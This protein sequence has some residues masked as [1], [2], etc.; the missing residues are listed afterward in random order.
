MKKLLIKF[1]FLCLAIHVN[2]QKS[3]DSLIKIINRDRRDT[4][5]VHAL[6]LLAN[7]LAHSD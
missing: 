2:A 7:Q 4:E 6:I 5:E 1:L 3:N